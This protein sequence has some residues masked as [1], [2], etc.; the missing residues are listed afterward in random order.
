MYFTSTKQI[1]SWRCR[2]VT[3]R[4]IPLTPEAWG[5]SA[6]GHFAPGVG[7]QTRCKHV[8]TQVL[9][10]AGFGQQQQPASGTRT[11]PWRKTAAASDSAGSKSDGNYFSIT[12]MQE[13]SSKSF[14]ELRWEDYQ[15]VPCKP[16]VLKAVVTCSQCLFLQSMFFDAL[17]T[18][19]HAMCIWMTS[20]GL[21]VAAVF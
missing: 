17:L 3:T 8:L 5:E 9:P 4:C 13:Y 20:N 18:C 6:C 15:V 19:L 21:A 1:G 7:C 10:P 11:V 14:E 16:N 2:S 12:A